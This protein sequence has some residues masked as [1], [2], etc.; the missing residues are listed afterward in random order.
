MF[1]SMATIWLNFYE[2]WWKRMQEINRW[3]Y[4]SIFLSSVSDTSSKI[5]LS[6]K[7]TSA[8]ALR[9]LR[10]GA[11]PFAQ[12]EIWKIYKWQTLCL[13]MTLNTHF[14]LHIINFLTKATPWWTDRFE[15]ILIY[16][17]YMNSLSKLDSIQARWSVELHTLEN[18]LRN[19][20]QAEAAS[21][22]PKI[23]FKNQADW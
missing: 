5:K 2:R 22:D 9:Q 16:N 3:I 19:T 14:S 10:Q 8:A 18:L 15:I 11:F 7:M 13:G 21:L 20:K 4:C 6:D 12:G 1:I 23:W 17:L